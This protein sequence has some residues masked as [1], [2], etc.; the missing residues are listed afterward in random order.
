MPRVLTCAEGNTD[1]PEMAVGVVIR[2][3]HQAVACRK[4][5]VEEPRKPQRLLIRGKLK[6]LTELGHARLKSQDMVW[7]LDESGHKE[8]TG[9]FARTNVEGVL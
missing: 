4:R 7:A 8:R 2:R 1:A 5:Y 9:R 6:Q 3:S